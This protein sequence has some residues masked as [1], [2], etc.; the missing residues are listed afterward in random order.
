MDFKESMYNRRQFLAHALWAA[1]LSTS[2]DSFAIE[3]GNWDAFSD[4]APDNVDNLTAAMDEVVPAGEGMP[5]ASMAGGREYLQF[6]RWQY[7]DVEENTRRFLEMLAQISAQMFGNEFQKLRPE[8]R[9][10]VLT[11]IEKT[12]S[13]IFESFVAYVYE[14]YYASPQVLG[15]I[16]CSAPPLSGEDEASLLSPVRR[17]THLRRVVP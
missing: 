8:Q 15:S 5:S 17:L 1:A 6:L 10:Q 9:V 11:T 16:S 7:P 14:S 12:Q 2:V 3:R 13:P 4:S